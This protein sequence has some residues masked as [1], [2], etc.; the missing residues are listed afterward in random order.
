MID[1]K[2]RG[3]NLHEMVRFSSNLKR[4]KAI[5]KQNNLHLSKEAPTT[6]ANRLLQNI[7]H[8]HSRSLPTNSN[9]AAVQEIGLSSGQALKKLIE[10]IDRLLKMKNSFK[11]ENDRHY[12]WRYSSLLLLA[13]WSIFKL[14]NWSL[15]FFCFVVFFLEIFFIEIIEKKRANGA[16]STSIREIRKK[17]RN[18]DKSL[19]AGT[20]DLEK[21]YSTVKER[22][23]SK[24]CNLFI[25]RNLKCQCLQQRVIRE[26]SETA[27]FD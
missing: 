7:S 9:V 23:T 3:T 5:A 12:N 6:A 22:M 15:G 16:V 27:K 24:N 18:L 21:L 11:R 10:E 19:L 17:M 20:V 13:G 2:H 8:M 25:F 1:T 26:S 14:K 4:P